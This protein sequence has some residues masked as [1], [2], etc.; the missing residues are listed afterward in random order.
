MITRRPWYATALMYV[1][2]TA[3]LLFLGF[4]LLWLL[5]ASFKSS[6]ELNSLAV[7]LLPATWDFSNYGSGARGRNRSC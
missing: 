2:L 1:A 3:F 7:N 4:P 6:G 5:S